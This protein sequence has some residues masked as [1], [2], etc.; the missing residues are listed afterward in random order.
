MSCHVMSCH[1]IFSPV[2][3]ITLRRLCSFLARK[4]S[5]KLA[6]KT[7]LTIRKGIEEKLLRD[8]FI[9]PIC[10]RLIDL[11]VAG[12]RQLIIDKHNIVIY[13]VDAE[14]KKIVV[15]LVFDSRQSI[16]KLLSDVNLII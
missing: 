4:Y 10:D 14:R 9:G 2:F 3:K 13:R 8:P 7:K 16:E 6:N 1:L 11:G 12:Y 15:L 5:E